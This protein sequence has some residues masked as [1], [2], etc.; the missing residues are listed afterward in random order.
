MSAVFP[1]ASLA[2]SSLVLTPVGKV[3]RNLLLTALFA[4]ASFFLDSAIHTASPFILF[5]HGSLPDGFVTYRLHV[6]D[7]V[8]S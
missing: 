8:I 4:F 7:G 3:D 5:C 6:E 1:C 2:V